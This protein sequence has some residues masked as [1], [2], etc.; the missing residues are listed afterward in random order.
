MYSKYCTWAYA[1]IVQ[2]F[3]GA[4]NVSVQIIQSNPGFSPITTVNPL[5]GC[6]KK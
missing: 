1:L 5:S 2:A 4:L 3:A 6:G